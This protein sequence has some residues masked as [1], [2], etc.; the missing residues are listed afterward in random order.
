MGSF[1]QTLGER[2][3]KEIQLSDPQ[4]RSLPK[5]FTTIVV[6]RKACGLFK[7]R[8]VL[9]GDMV[10][11]AVQQFLSAPTAARRMIRVILSVAANLYLKVGDVDVSH[12]FLQADVAHPE[13]R[14]VAILPK[15]L[16]IPWAGKILTDQQTGSYPPVTKGLLTASPLYGG[17]DAPIR[18]FIRIS[19]SLR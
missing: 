6:K 11:L 2:Q 16:P 18:W 13:E 15:W 10:P 1:S 9:R 4:Y 12:A 14:M 19:T 3:H 7:A 8:L 17:R 5:V